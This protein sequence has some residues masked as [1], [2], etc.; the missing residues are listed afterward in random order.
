MS[1]KYNA[2]KVQYDGYTFDSGAEKLRYCELCL[3][4]DGGLIAGLQVH[5]TFSILAK[6]TDN[7]GVNERGISYTADFSYIDM[8]TGGVLVVEDV[9]SVITARKRD[10]VI[11]RKLFKCKYPDIHFRELVY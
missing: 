11:I 5:P 1:N 9:K 4:Q 7:E 10:Y 8:E 2:R 3:L 6:F